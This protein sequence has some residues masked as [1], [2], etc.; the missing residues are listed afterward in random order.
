MEQLFWKLWTKR[1]SLSMDEVTRGVWLYINK[2]LENLPDTSVSFTNPRLETICQAPLF[3]GVRLSLSKFSYA[4]EPVVNQWLA[5]HWGSNWTIAEIHRSMLCWCI[6]PVHRCPSRKFFL[7]VL[8]V[9]IVKKKMAR[10]CEDEL[11]K[12]FN[13]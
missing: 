6:D 8:I 3:G 4:I 9:L 11:I 2:H 7:E 13:F 5:Y 10:T 1:H 12:P